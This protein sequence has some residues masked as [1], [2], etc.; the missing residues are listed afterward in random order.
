[1]LSSDPDP[2][3]LLLREGRL[4][5]TALL[6]LWLAALVLVGGTSAA[7]VAAQQADTA[8]VDEVVL[9]EPAERLAPGRSPAPA[10]RPSRTTAARADRDPA[11]GAPAPRP[12]RRT[13]IGAASP[14]ATK[15]ALEP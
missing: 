4:R 12:K 5:R 13:A 2:G 6:G 11:V 3:R 10:E 9:H 14:P 1:M 7:L 8:I 15:P